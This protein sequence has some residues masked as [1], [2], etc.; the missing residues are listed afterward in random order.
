MDLSAQ[1]F[2]TL[3]RK[4][5]A[6]YMY[7]ALKF[8][9]TYACERTW[10]AQRSKALMLDNKVLELRPITRNSLVI[11]VNYETKRIGKL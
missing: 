3:C 11:E 4:R 8:G 6:M 1:R 9:I 10:A 5:M 7:I 2:I